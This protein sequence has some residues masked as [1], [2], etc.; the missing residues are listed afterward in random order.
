MLSM[1]GTLS[2]TSTVV[3]RLVMA[4]ELLVFFFLISLI[5]IQMVR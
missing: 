4:I 5:L 2:R 3:V 1:Y